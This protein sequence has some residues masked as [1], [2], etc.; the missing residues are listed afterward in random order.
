[1]NDELTWLDATETAERV[2]RGDV[3]AREVVDSA[4]ARIEQQNPALNAVIHPRFERARDE[5]ARVDDRH[6]AGDIDPAPFAGVPFLLKDAVCHSAG[7]PFHAG[8]RALKNAQYVSPTDT[9]LAARFKAAGFLLVGRT[10]VPE[11]ATSATT[12]PLAYGATHN[13]W[14]MDRSPGGSSGGSGAAVAAG[15]VPVAHGNDMGGSIRIPAAFNGLV[16]LKPSRARITIGP[17]HGEYWAQLTHEFVLTRTVRDCAAVLD[18]V[19]G[20]APGD[21]YV[22]PL[23]LRPY[24]SEVG[25]AMRPLRIAMRTSRLDGRPTDPEIATAVEG[26]GATLNLIGHQVEPDPLTELEGD[27]PRVAMGVVIAAWIARELDQWEERLGRAIGDD[28]LEPMTVLMRER[29]RTMRAIDYIA[30]QQVMQSYARQA[31]RWTERADVL[32]L[33]TS[34]IPAP[35]LGVISPVPTIVDPN[36]DPGSPAHFTV[37]FDVTGEPAISLPLAWSA[38]GMPIGVQFVAPYGREDLL[39]ALAA[40]LEMACPWAHRRPPHAP[41]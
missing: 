2:R 30:G 13:P 23:P 12:E 15:F 17:D 11:F 31:A 29:G 41:L 27:G 4:I 7:D 36:V 18:A 20:G 22:A 10:N 35:R 24:A 39:L 26:V 16:G 25:A 14:N 1:M 3:S 38:D 8:C 5:A 32:L 37:P 21:P 19:H 6:A 9:Y 28:E 40:Q 34:P 33:P